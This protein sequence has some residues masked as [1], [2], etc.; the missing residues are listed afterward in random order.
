MLE[1]NAGCM[2]NDALHTV[3]C[4]LQRLPSCTRSLSPHYATDCANGESVNMQSKHVRQECQHDHA[5]SNYT[6]ALER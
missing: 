1:R 4:N 2:H 6:S 3:V 5:Y